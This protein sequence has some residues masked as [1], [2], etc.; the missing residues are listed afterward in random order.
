MTAGG[1]VAF[2]PV[3]LAPDQVHSVAFRGESRLLAPRPPAGWRA[4]RDARRA[5]WPA[6]GPGR[7]PRRAPCVFVFG[8]QQR[9]PEQFALFQPGLFSLRSRDILANRAGL[10]GGIGRAGAVPRPASGS[11]G[12]AQPGR[13]LVQEPGLVR[14]VLAG[15]ERCERPGRSIGSAKPPSTMTPASASTASRR[16]RPPGA[17]SRSGK[18][19]GRSADRQLTGRSRAPTVRWPCPWARLSENQDDRAG[20]AGQQ[21]DGP[22]TLAAVAQRRPAYRASPG[23]H[24]GRAPDPGRRRPAGRRR[25]H[26]P[27]TALAAGP[28]PGPGRIR[29]RR[30]S[31]ACCSAASAAPLPASARSRA[32]FAVSRSCSATS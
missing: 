24:T 29:R 32:S 21:T 12:G 16:R 22:G 2:S 18:Q 14:V 15:G 19:P 8:G 10:L 1:V 5:G 25:A 27:G 28:R 11:S 17:R 31:R 7:A 13:G 30:G 23:S 3:G 4:G 9:G 20:Q 6:S 26:R